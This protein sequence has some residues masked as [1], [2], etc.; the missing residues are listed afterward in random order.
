MRTYRPQANNPPVA[1]MRS[2]WLPD[3]GVNG[4]PSP[5]A[6]AG[7]QL[8]EV[9]ASGPDPVGVA[10]QVHRQLLDHRG[11]ADEG[12]QV[13]DRKSTRL[14]SS[15]VSISYAVFCLKKKIVC[16]ISSD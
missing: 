13:G 7:Q 15:H 6:A 5:L 1:G 16:Y 8:A 4:P 9:R 3:G 10:E 14:N 2:L 12:N 11:Q